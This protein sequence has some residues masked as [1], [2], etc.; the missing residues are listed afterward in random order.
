MKLV[1]SSGFVWFPSA[2]KLFHE[3]DSETAGEIAVKLLLDPSV[4]L[5]AKLPTKFQ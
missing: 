3:I 1:S 4:K 2:H 5:L